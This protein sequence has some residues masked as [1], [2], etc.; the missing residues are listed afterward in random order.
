M[1]IIKNNVIRHLRHFD[2]SIAKYVKIRT[3]PYLLYMN[4]IYI[5]HDQKSR[6]FY[7]ILRSKLESRPNMESIH[8]RNFKFEN[9]KSAWQNIYKQ[10]ICDINIVRIKEFNFKLINNILPCGKILNKWQTNVSAKCEYCSQIETIQHMIYECERVKIIW[11][12][13]SEIIKCNIMLKTITCGWPSYDIS[14]K[15]YC[16]N[17]I[18]SIVTYAIFRINSH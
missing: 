5:I 14:K 9:T 16:F 4:R 11:K 12:L 17:V 2:S 3:K 18:I 8:A 1:F 15:L 10:K 7:K 13:I 6:F